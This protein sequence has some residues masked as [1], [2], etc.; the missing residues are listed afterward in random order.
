MKQSRRK[1]SPSFKARVAM[2]ALKGEQTVAELAKRFEVHPAQVRNGRR[3][4]LKEPPT[5]SLDL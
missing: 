4:S 5:S 1:H 2:E 3:T